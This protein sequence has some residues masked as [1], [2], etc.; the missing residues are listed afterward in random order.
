[1]HK[2]GDSNFY[3]RLLLCVCF[4]MLL[5]STCYADMTIWFQD[6][7]SRKV[8][9]IVFKGEVADLYLIDGRVLNVRVQQLDLKSSG[10]DSPVGTYGETKLTTRDSLTGTPGKSV[11]PP[12]GLKQ[13]QLKEEWEKSESVAVAEKEIGAIR[14]GQK[15]KIISQPGSAIP[16]PDDDEP[17]STDDAYVIIY[18]NPDGSFSKKVFDAS[19]FASN[20]KIVQSRSSHPA[21]P[22]V[23]VLPPPFPS[24]PDEDVTQ[25]SLP[26][27]LPDDTRIE[28]ESSD[29]GKQDKTTPIL[30]QRGTKLIRKSERGFPVLLAGLILVAMIAAI[31]MLLLKNKRPRVFIDSSRFRQ[32]EEELRDFELELWIKHGKTAEQLT[33]I[34]VK[35]YYQDS[36]E[37][38]N[39]ALKMLKTPD[40]NTI[41]PLIAK[42]APKGPSQADSLYLDMKGRIE[43]IRQLIREVQGRKTQTPSAKPP[44]PAAIQRPEPIKP[45]P[46]Q[47]KPVPP[48]DTKSRVTSTL[49]PDDEAANLRIPTGRS[50]LPSYFVNVLSQ[51][52]L[53]TLPEDSEASKM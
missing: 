50:D 16:N 30:K 13:A 6:G 28:E 33:E 42:H 25:D 17:V 36:P 53:L 52:S 18:I 48:A 24:T 4:L 39:I 20:F 44:T 2:R 12:G 37:A 45:A 7:T 11:V 32:Y 5:L 27:A 21:E 19:T 10:I 40:R 38:L 22:S 1:M 26:I 31:A 47:P 3:A 15:V 8:H 14:Q 49:S 29:S 51:L 9:K 41:V 46:A 23:D 34:C 35:K 43:W